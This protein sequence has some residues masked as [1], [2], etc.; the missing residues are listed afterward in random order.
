ML[1]IEFNAALVLSVLPPAV[2]LVL[3]F[4]LK[5]D[6]VVTVAAVMSVCYS[7][8]MLA[9]P[10]ILIGTFFQSPDLDYLCCMCLA[11]SLSLHFLT[12]YQ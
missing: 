12:D 3:C 7:I 10:M 6:T 5:S 1:N 9:L 11:I 2:Y 4:K 8:F